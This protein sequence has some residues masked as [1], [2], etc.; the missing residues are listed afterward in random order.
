[1]RAVPLAVLIA[2]LGLPSAAHAATITVSAPGSSARTLTVTLGGATRVTVARNG[3]DVVVSGRVTD[4]VNASGCTATTGGFACGAESTFSRIV[5]NGSAGNDEIAISPSISRA[6]TLDG[7]NGADELTGGAGADTIVGD[8]GDDVISGGD[9]H[10]DLNG[11]A[12]V[13]V[14]VGDGGTDN[15]DGGA[16]ADIMSG[17]GQAG[18]ALDYAGRT[19]PVTI[20]LTGATP[21][22]EANEGDAVDG[23]AVALGGAGGDTLLGGAGNERLEGNGGADLLLGAGGNDTLNGAA[24]A[25]RLEGGDGADALSGGD[26]DDH[27]Y[28]GDGIDTLNGGAGADRLDGGAGADALNGGDGDDQLDARDQA[29]DGTLNCGAGRDGLASDPADPA[30]VGCEVLAPAVIGEV[31]VSGAAT[32]GGTLGANFEGVITGSARTSAFR[33]ERCAAGACAPVGAGPTY[34]PT[35]A[36]VGAQLRVVLRAE[37]EAGA[38]EG[39]SA[40]VG[41]VPAVQPAAVPPAPPPAPAPSN[42]AAVVRSVKCT[43]HRCRVAL[44]VSGQATRVRAVLTR[45][46]KAVASATRRSPAPEFTLTVTSR[47]ALARGTYRLT[48]TA[49]GTDTRTRS[50]TRTVHVTR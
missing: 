23:F 44:T 3:N 8:N 15:V 49:T 18:D 13:D 48:V 28:G 21:S 25:D 39:A 29:A 33:W 36:D 38:G 7:N 22:G 41:P 11:S 17:G 14:I 42:A 4:T 20:D 50:V 35:V 47:R 1:M 12:G 2:A 45:R 37:N 16:G 32:V 19:A 5:V 46:G 26:G 34:A 30:G 9:G 43:K 40:L 31:Q 24:G 6:T 10:D 27:L